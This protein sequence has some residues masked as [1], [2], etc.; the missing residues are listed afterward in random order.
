MDKK[1]FGIGFLLVVAWLIIGSGVGQSYLSLPERV[2]PAA[3]QP[4]D[5]ELEF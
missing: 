2:L 4:L 1:R 3:H 5:S